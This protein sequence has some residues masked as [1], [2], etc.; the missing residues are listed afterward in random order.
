MSLYPAPYTAFWASHICQGHGLELHG[1]LLR[2]VQLPQAPLSEVLDSSRPEPRPPA[3]QPDGAP[4]GG[5]A[6]FPGDW[7]LPSLTGTMLTAAHSGS[8][9]WRAGS[10]TQLCLESVFS[11]MPGAFGQAAPSP[12]DGAGGGC[13]AGGGGW[14]TEAGAW[15]RDAP[16]GGRRPDSEPRPT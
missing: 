15:P 9:A 10:L 4:E 3:A 6:F 11:P 5:G 12:T 2:P 14:N 7:W 8:C 13:S 16:G 1:C